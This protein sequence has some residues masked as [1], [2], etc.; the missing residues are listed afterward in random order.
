MRVLLIDADTRRHALS[1]SIWTPGDYGLVELLTLL[2]TPV[3]YSLFDDMIH[4]RQRRRE[5]RAAREA[6][7][8]TEQD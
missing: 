3:I 6:A 7:Q 5:K 4:F 2:A 8:G 1:S